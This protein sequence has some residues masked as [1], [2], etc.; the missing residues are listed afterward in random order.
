[1]RP[2]DPATLAPVV[3]TIVAVA[4]AA[5]WLPAWRASRLDPNAVLRSD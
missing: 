5:R 2:T 4:I 3:M 1:V